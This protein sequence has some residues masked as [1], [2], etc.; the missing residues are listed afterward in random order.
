MVLS[1]A[2]QKDFFAFS[3]CIIYGFFGSLS[4]F[5]SVNTLTAIA[6][7]RYFVIV[8]Q[9]PW[10]K[11]TSSSKICLSVCFVW[12][13]SFAWSLC[14][15]FGWGHYILEGS[16]TSCTFD[17]FTRTITNYSFVI[18]ILIFCFFL[19]VLFIFISYLGIF[20][21]VAKHERELKDMSETNNGSLFCLRISKYRKSEKCEIKTAKVAFCIIVIFCL[22]WF[23]YAIVCM[24]GMFGHAEV[25]FPAASAIPGLCAKSV[26]VIN[27]FVYALLHP[28]F[29]CKL[30]RWYFNKA[31]NRQFTQEC[32]R[33]P[34]RALVSSA[35]G[36]EF[37]DSSDDASLREC[38]RSLINNGSNNGSKQAT[39]VWKKRT[40]CIAFRH[41]NLLMDS[42]LEAP[43]ILPMWVCGN[44]TFWQK[45]KKTG[46][47]FSEDG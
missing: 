29:R 32:S 7:E 25:I 33:N 46:S 19:Q 16:L 13:F 22:S 6:L 45:G 36:T 30:R 12:I 35:K 3:G 20:I 18:S 39:L 1:L 21:K 42:V 41:A 31:P 37:C 17:F 34:R 27:P 40:K 26:T 28:K 14:P 9:R 4:S 2:N 10:Y 11:K 24:I 15:I 44:Y 43:S 5:L 47:A 23:P 8:F 38:Q